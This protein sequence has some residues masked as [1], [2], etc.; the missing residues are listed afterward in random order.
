M[1]ININGLL[2]VEG[3]LDESYLSS[4]LEVEI[5]KTSGYQIPIEEIEYLKSS[6]KN[7]IILTDSDQAG[8][9]IRNR[10]N[11]LLPTAINVRVD[12][13]KCNKNNKHGVAEAPKEEILRVLK[14]YVIDAPLIKGNLTTF[15]LL[16]LGLTGSNSKSNKE[17]IIK[18]FKLG[19][20]NS[21]TLLKRL[22]YRNIT[23]EQ[24]IEVINGNK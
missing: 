12:I 4:F 6:N 1:K 2:I 21:K 24:L 19:L 8:E 11:K 13:T 5:V 20:S 7:L 18:T 14:D 16:E 23:K 22:N 3:I 15:D 10:L 17:L 9:T